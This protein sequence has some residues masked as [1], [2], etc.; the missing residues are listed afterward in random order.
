MRLVHKTD[1]SPGRD[2]WCSHSLVQ[3]TMR[4]TVSR[5]RT[6]QSCQRG[7]VSFIHLTPTQAPV[8]A[9]AGGFH[10]CCFVT[11]NPI[12]KKVSHSRVPPRFLPGEPFPREGWTLSS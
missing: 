3:E 1:S 12:F 9:E 2:L 8:P 11:L 5:L 6:T 4:G 10:C 7:Q